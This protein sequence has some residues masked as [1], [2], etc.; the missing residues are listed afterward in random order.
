MANSIGTLEGVNYAIIDDLR[1]EIFGVT[2]YK[3]GFG[4]MIDNESVEPVS[5][6]GAIRAC[7]ETNILFGS[8]VKID[9][10]VMGATQA[11]AFFLEGGLNYESLDHAIEGVSDDGCSYIDVSNV[12]IGYNQYTVRIMA[13]VPGNF[14]A[15]DKDGNML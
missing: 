7:I 2:G 6:V 13:D 4:W 9:M 5:V 1:A 8:S 11:V 12:T 3:F 10:V 14:Y 15:A